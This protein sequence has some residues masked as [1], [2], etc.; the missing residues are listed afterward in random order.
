MLNKLTIN[1]FRYLVVTALLFDYGC[2]KPKEDQ[3]TGNLPT[4]LPI[5][6]ST[7]RLVNL[8]G[9]PELEING[10]TLTSLVHATDQGQI[11]SAVPTVY[12]PSTGKMGST[13]NVPQEFVD[14]KGNAA[15]HLFKFPKP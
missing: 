12:F 1:F 5:T 9:Y 6:A 13:Y 14:S 10:K 3:R 15:V 8:G 4:S 11:P 2:S 7:V